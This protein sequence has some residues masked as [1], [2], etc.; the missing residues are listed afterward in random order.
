MNPFTQWPSYTRLGPDH[1][2]VPTDSRHFVEQMGLVLMSNGVK[3]YVKNHWLTS[4]SELHCKY[5]W[6]DYNHVR[7]LIFNCSDY[8]LAVW[9]TIVGCTIYIVENYYSSNDTIEQFVMWIEGDGTIFK[10]MYSHV[11]TLTFTWH[12]WVHWL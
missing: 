10:S 1:K 11:T 8:N 5:L 4:N 12:M 6:Q 9:L 3:P 2:N 7:L